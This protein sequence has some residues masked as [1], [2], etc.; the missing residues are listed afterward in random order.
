MCPHVLR[1]TLEHD[2]DIDM[3]IFRCFRLGERLLLVGSGEFKCCNRNGLH[4]AEVHSSKGNVSRKK[5]PASQ[6][7]NQPANRPWGTR[8]HK[9]SPCAESTTTTEEL[10]DGYLSTSMLQAYRFCTRSLV[11]LLGTPPR[12]CGTTGYRTHASTSQGRLLPNNLSH[13]LSVPRG[14]FP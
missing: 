9:E 11:R 14:A 1:S 12:T 8:R 13:C 10:T 5:G 3:G 4:L 7:K 6:P 2:I